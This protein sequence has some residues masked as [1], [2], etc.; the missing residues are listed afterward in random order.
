VACAREFAR[1]VVASVARSAQ[2]AKP[3][4]HP[5]PSWGD[6]ACAAS[7][8]NTHRPSP[9]L[10]QNIM[11]GVLHRASNHIL[12]FCVIND[13]ILQGV[14]LE[15][16]LTFSICGLIHEDQNKATTAGPQGD[17]NQTY[18]CTEQGKGGF[19]SHLRFW[20]LLQLFAAVCSHSR[21]R[22]GKE[23][24]RIFS[25]SSDDLST[26]HHSTLHAFAHMQPQ[27]L[28]V[29]CCCI[30]VVANNKKMG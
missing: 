2:S 15:C 7:P 22:N 21:G 5:T 24:S 8:M 23:T 27:A 16:M 12:C 10:L 25:S 19:W 6:T 28:C 18:Q 4:E 9:S 17:R 30:A 13:L 29:P 20:G 1:R 14:S 26:F 3:D 11:L